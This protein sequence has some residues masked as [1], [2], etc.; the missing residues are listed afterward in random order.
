MRASNNIPNSLS[1]KTDWTVTPR[2]PFLTFQV[3][4]M[5]GV[6]ATIPNLS[7]DVSIEELADS[8]ELKQVSAQSNQT[9]SARSP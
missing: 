8:V 7:E 6:G 5:A 2:G 3:K 1:D 4:R 9:I